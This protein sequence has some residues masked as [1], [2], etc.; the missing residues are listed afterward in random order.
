M[1]LSMGLHSRW[2]PLGRGYSSAGPWKA[3]ASADDSVGKQASPSRKTRDGEASTKP[4]LSA[5]LAEAAHCWAGRP[6]FYERRW[7]IIRMP[8]FGRSVTD[9]KY[10]TFWPGTGVSLNFCAIVASNKTASIIAN[11][12]PTHALGPPPNGK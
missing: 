2:P 4:P 12:A 3:Q 8:L 11:P 9:G 5:A 10:L 6:S 7:A 1:L